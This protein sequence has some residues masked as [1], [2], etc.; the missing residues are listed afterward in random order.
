MSGWEP[1][2]G[3]WD[4]IENFDIQTPIWRRMLNTI[5]TTIKN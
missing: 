5:A 2:I 1:T 3:K 4:D